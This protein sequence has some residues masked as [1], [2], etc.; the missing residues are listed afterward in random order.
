MWSRSRNSGI[1]GQRPLRTRTA[2]L[3]LCS[4]TPAEN[5]RVNSANRVLELL[6]WCAEQALQCR[7]KAVALN[8][9]FLEDL[10]GDPSDRPS[11][12]WTLREI[13]LMEGTRD[14]R[15]AAG[16]CCQFTGAE[17]K[18]P[19]GVLSTSHQLRS[20][21]HLGWPT[22]ERIHDR[23]IYKSPLPKK[24][25]CGRRHSPLVGLSK[26]DEF[27]TALRNPLL[28]VLISG[29][30][31]FWTFPW[32]RSSFPFG[33]EVSTV[34]SLF[35]QQWAF[36][37]SFRYRWRQGLAH[38]DMFMRHGKLVLLLGPCSLTSQTRIIA[39]RICPHLLGSLCSRLRGRSCAPCGK[40]PRLP[41]LA[42]LCLFLL[43]AQ[44]LLFLCVLL[45][46]LGTCALALAHVR[47]GPCPTETEGRC[48]TLSVRC[49][50]S[51]FPLFNNISSFFVL[52]FNN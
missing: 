31:A 3:G 23:L 1:P 19:T 25:A 34:I 41:L 46:G 36:P 11:S 29:I 24:C 15:R 52:S 51:Q 4:L 5:D 16:Y 43:V 26:D 14:A 42:L 20:R 39:A 47:K 30:F 8:V 37:H 21:L 35:W 6:L 9:I 18:R 48:F 32:T 7:T 40:F 2:P 33:M 10:G 38:Y 50:A 28:S 22:F 44:A 27:N 49:V 45:S 17:S 13:Q 12:S